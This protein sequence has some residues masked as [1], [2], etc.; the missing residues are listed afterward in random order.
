[1]ANPTELS[2]RFEVRPLGPGHID[3]AKAIGSHSNI[4][5]SPVWPKV[6]PVDKT[7]RAYDLFNAVDYLM[8]YQIESGLSYGVFDKEYQFKRPESENIGGALYWDPSDVNATSEELLEQ[9]DFPLV[10]IAMALDEAKPMDL[11]QL[12]PVF[13]VLPLF[14]VIHHQLDELDARDPASWQP[15]A[16]GEVLSRNGTSTRADYG[17][18]GI[19][20]KMAHWLMQEAAHQGFRGIRIECFHDAVHHVW[21]NPPEPYQAT[22]V[23][24]LNVKDIEEERDG[25]AVKPYLHLEQLGSKVF[26]T[27]R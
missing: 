16:C 18:H 6:H 13:K 10:S 26:V 17:G 27:L 20:K 23:S 19:M 9:M 12:S 3:W 25:K 4:F 22:V 1:M 8:R 24:I 15:K 21:T 11:T 2:P 14:A 7:K 5:H